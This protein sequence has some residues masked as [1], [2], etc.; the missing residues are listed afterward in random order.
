MR[1]TC[2]LNGENRSAVYQRHQCS[3]ETHNLERRTQA[4]GVGY[5]PGATFFENQRAARLARARRRFV[6]SLYALAFATVPL[7]LALLWVL[8]KLVAVFWEAP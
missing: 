8:V 3:H 6:L 4:P 7:L 2:N 5:T 1:M